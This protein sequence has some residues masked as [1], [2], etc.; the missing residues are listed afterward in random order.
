MHNVCH[1]VSYDVTNTFWGC[2]V[3]VHAHALNCRQTLP[4][5]AVG[6][7]SVSLHHYTPYHFS[8][9]HD[10][11]WSC[12]VGVQDAMMIYKNPSAD[13]GVYVHTKCMPLRSDITNT[14]KTSFMV[15]QW[16]FKPTH[17]IVTI[18]QPCCRCTNCLFAT[19]CSP[20]F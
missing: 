17:L 2:T 4:Q 5:V 7:K 12:T 11:I 3:D 6:V 20:P 19:A 9:M 14:Y 8:N 13:L 16:K 18:I 10:N 15:L 1:Y